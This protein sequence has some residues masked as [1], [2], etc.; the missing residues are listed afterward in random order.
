[1]T[2]TRE[3]HST[4]RVARIDSG[5]DY[6][7]GL[8]ARLLVQDRIDAIHRERSADRLAATF[9]RS[10]DAESLRSGGAPRYR[11]LIATIR[12]LVRGRRELRGT[13]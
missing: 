6:G 7:P 1:M 2:F 10:R 13:A 5:D 9:R 8:V 12:A 4:D 11:R 3:Q